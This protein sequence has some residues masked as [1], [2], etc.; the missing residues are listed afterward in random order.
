ML[1]IAENL[2]VLSELNALMQ[3]SRRFHNLFNLELYERDV[4][5]HRRPYDNM[6]L[7]GRNP[8]QVNVEDFLIEAAKVGV[9]A[10][11]YVNSNRS[12]I[13]NAAYYAI[14]WG[15]EKALILLVK[16]GLRIE[17]YMHNGMSLLKMAMIYD[18]GNMVRILIDAGLNPNHHI[19]GG[20][21]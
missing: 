12:L 5:S 6:D 16:H 10:R 11:P 9:E 1:P 2:T 7:E 19:L 15:H 3:T 18:R 8:S 20:E 4:R 14:R 21:I 17:K 13:R